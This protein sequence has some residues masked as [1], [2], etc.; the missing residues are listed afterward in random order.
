MPRGLQRPPGCGI[1]KRCA[2]DLKYSLLT[3]SAE[4]GVT[5]PER[6]IFAASLT[7]GRMPGCAGLLSAQPRDAELL[8]H[9]SGVKRRMVGQ[10][11]ISALMFSGQDRPSPR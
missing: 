4:W 3:E 2:C 6:P 7:I 10:I 9:D 8:R 5:H 11:P 1:R